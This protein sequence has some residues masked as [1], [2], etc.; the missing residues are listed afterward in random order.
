MKDL[1]QQYIEENQRLESW[2]KMKEEWNTL[3]IQNLDELI[4][5]QENIVTILLLKIDETKDEVDQILE[6]KILSWTESKN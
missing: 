5:N 1:Q 2:K 6:N 3:N 4:K